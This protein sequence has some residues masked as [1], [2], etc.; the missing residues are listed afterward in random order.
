V[1]QCMILMTVL[2]LAIVVGV[3]LVQLWV[4]HPVFVRESLYF[5]YAEAYPTAVF[6]LVIMLGVVRNIR[7]KQSNGCSN[8]PH[9][10]CFLGTFDA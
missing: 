8:W 6:I 10:S 3:G 2:V 5:D 4:D 7:W 1:H 9:I